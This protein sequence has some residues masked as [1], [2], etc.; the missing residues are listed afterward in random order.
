MLV[1]WEP[2]LGVR[3]IGLLARYCDN[4]CICFDTDQ[5]DA[6]LLG[7]FRTLAD[8]YA[9]GIGM[10]PSTWKLTTIHL[11]VK[12]D[13]D[14]YIEQYGLESFLAL[15]I[16]IGED[17]LKNAENAYTQLKWRM[18]ERQNKEMAEA[19]LKN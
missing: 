15:E 1:L 10:Q 16:P 19:L 18:K 17:L 12:V 7:L 14:E 6:G 11:P 2:I 9:I 3:R 5:N 8:M 13:P 4:I